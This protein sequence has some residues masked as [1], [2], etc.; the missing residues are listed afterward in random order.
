MPKVSDDYSEV[1]HYTGVS[2][3]AGILMT[4]TLWATHAEFLNDREEYRL[5]FS[6]RFPG[7]LRQAIDR[8]FDSIHDP[9]VR[10]RIADPLGGDHAARDKWF[11]NLLPHL[12]GG[13]REMEEPY[14]TSFCATRSPAVADHGLLSQWR[15]YGRDGGY[16][17]V[18]DTQGLEELW[19]REAA[20]LNGMSMFW[21]D[22]EYVG[23]GATAVDRPEAREDS[24]LMI[25]SIADWLRNDMAPAYLEPL[26]APAHRLACLTKHWGFEEEHEVRMV[27]SHPSAKLRNM[28]PEEFKLKRIHH[29]V[30]DGVPVPHMALFEDLGEDPRGRLPIKR[31]I[32]G[33]HPDRLARKVAVELLL[34]QH[35]YSAAVT[36]SEI[37]YRGS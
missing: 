34:Q 22:V 2:G 15:G 28:A 27:I 6:H 37:P 21:G 19:P 8:A 16:A 18:F 32:I 30:R 11:E 4:G 26:F 12:A 25:R 17:V 14:V 36:A 13:I 31:V 33:P 1:F 10:S 35:G 7:L 9:R 29:F 24:E 20:T 3:L 23:A 5:F